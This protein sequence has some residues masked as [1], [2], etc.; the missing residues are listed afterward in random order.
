LDDSKLNIDAN[1]F[2]GLTVN[3]ISVWAE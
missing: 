2:S 3:V 1:R